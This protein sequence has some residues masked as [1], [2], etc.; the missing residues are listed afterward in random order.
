LTTHLEKTALSEKMIKENLSQ[1][2]DCATKS[3]HR[4]DVGF[5]RCEK[6]VRRVLLSLFL[7]SATI[8]KRNH[9]NQSKPITHPI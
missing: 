2:E 4:L 9:S 6:K 5:E 7:A 8:K 3:T 1:V